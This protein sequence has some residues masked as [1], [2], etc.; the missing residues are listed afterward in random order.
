MQFDPSRTLATKDGC[1]KANGRWGEKEQIWNDEQALL[2]KAT[3][4]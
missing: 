4:K 3:I 1:A 2:A